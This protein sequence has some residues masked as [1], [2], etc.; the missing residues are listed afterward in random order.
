LALAPG[1]SQHTTRMLLHR[2]LEP[3]GGQH[4]DAGGCCVGDHLLKDLELSRG[5]LHKHM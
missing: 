5:G 1:D 2:E 3:K 4:L